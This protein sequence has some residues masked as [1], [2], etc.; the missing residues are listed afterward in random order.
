MPDGPRQEGPSRPTPIKVLGLIVLLAACLASIGAAQILGQVVYLSTMSHPHFP[1]ASM[2]QTGISSA[3][4]AALM[5]LTGWSI[6]RR[7]TDWRGALISS[8]ATLVSGIYSLAVW[9]SAAGW[10]SWPFAG[11]GIWTSVI[12]GTVAL[13]SLLALW[14]L[15][16]PGEKSSASPPRL[17]TP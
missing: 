4:S 5:A 6:L 12:I 15:R 17:R 2:L 11:I 14:I 7:S 16:I 10:Y 3:V 13:V 1:A 9:S 8:L